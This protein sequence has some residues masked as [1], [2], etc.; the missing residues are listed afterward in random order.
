MVLEFS[1]KQIKEI[2]NKI[3]RNNEGNHLGMEGNEEVWIITIRHITDKKINKDVIKDRRR[4][5]V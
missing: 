5:G 1:K 2:E 3:D 4:E